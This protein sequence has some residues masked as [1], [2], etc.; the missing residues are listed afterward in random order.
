[1]LKNFLQQSLLTGYINDKFLKDFPNSLLIQSNTNYK[2]SIKNKKLLMQFFIHF[3][4]KEDKNLIKTDLILPILESS[5]NF[6]I[7]WGDNT[8]TIIHQLNYK[9]N[10]NTEKYNNIGDYYIKII[11]DDHDNII[12]EDVYYYNGIGFVKSDISKTDICNSNNSYYVCIELSNN[13]IT[14]NKIFLSYNIQTYTTHSYNNQGT[15]IVKIEGGFTGFKP[16]TLLNTNYF[17]NTTQ[18][19]YK[20][21]LFIDCSLNYDFPDLAGEYHKINNQYVN[22]SDELNNI[23]PKRKLLITNNNCL[24]ISGTY[25]KNIQEINTTLLDSNDIITT[26]LSAHYYKP[27]IQKVYLEKILSWGTNTNWQT[28]EA[29]FYDAQRLNELPENSLPNINNY[30][31]AF[32]GCTNLTDIPYNI[33]PRA[34]IYGS[35]MFYNSGIKNTPSGFIFPPYLCVIDNM[36]NQNINLLSIKNYD[37][38]K[39]YFKK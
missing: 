12:A 30:T 20:N 19:T 35:Y 17:Y 4:E 21:T 3:Y 1:M 2:L 34:I 14:K 39:N 26:N 24:F 33:L 36:F 37:Q 7:E 38:M 5:K 23:Q 6:T 28:M 13:I 9:A 18:Q 32:Y 25:T 10:A 27:I 22:Y 15:Y 8:K 16:N 29:A 31:S 11:K